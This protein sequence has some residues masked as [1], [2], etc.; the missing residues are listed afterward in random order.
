MP[1][2]RTGQVV[3]TEIQMGTI[4]KHSQSPAGKLPLKILRSGSKSY[5]VIEAWTGKSDVFSG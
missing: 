4:R 1:G 2:T 5:L 3:V